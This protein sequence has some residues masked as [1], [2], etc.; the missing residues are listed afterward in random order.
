MGILTGIRAQID[1]L[2]LPLHAATVSAV[3]RH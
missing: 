1:A 2:R 3:R